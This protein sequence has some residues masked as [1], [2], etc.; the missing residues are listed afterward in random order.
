[1]GLSPGA[2]HWGVC[3]H[4]HLLPSLIPSHPCRLAREREGLQLERDGL[5]RE[6]REA[7]ECREVGA[8]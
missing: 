7:T 4:R 5:C 1:M 6:L 3:P 2:R 8:A